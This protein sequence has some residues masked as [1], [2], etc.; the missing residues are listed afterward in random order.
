MGDEFPA[1][2]DVKKLQ[3]ERDGLLARV[4]ELEL[5]SNTDFSLIIKM[6][7]LLAS[8]AFSLKGKPDER[9]MHSVHDLPDIALRLREAAQALVAGSELDVDI[10]SVETEHLRDLKAALSTHTESES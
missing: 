7:D 10:S 4:A 1:D 9:T 5:E 3:A 6:S 2:A 8:V